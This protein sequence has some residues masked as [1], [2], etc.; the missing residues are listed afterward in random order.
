MNPNLNRYQFNPLLSKLRSL[1]TQLSLLNLLKPPPSRSITTVSAV[2]MLTL[3]RAHNML[4]LSSKLFNL[5]LPNS[6]NLNKR[7]MIKL[8]LYKMRL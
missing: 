8:K 3:S 5:L 1:K 6:M 4:P 7:L 2:S